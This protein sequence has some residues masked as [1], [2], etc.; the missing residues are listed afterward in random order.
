[1]VQ[2]TFAESSGST[3]YQGWGNRDQGAAD[4]EPD[5]ESRSGTGAVAGIS[6]KR[7]NHAQ[8]ACSDASDESFKSQTSGQ[9]EQTRAHEGA[10][11]AG[12]G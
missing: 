12:E 5:Y 6:A 4:A 10:A 3:N 2:A 1:M 8:E 11:E 7:D 9:Q